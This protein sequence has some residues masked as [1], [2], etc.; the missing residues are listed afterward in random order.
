MID[1]KSSKSDSDQTLAL[2]EKLNFGVDNADASLVLVRQEI[3]LGKMVQPNWKLV[4]LAQAR[5]L[6]K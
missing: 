3:G 6:S 2:T 5:S 4:A 1:S